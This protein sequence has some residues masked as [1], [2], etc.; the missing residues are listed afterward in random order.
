MIN[1]LRQASCERCHRCRQFPCTAA[2]AASADLR[3]PWAT[4]RRVRLTNSYQQE[5]WRNLVPACYPIR[6]LVESCR[7]SPYF[8][9]TP[10]PERVRFPFVRQ[11]ALVYP[12]AMNPRESVMPVLNYVGEGVV[13]GVE[14]VLVSNPDDL[15][16]HR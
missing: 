4:Q 14:D 10:F 13:L 11:V 15:M 9:C 1:H 2:S 16:L 7:I 12:L 3:Q 5:W 8:P 6:S